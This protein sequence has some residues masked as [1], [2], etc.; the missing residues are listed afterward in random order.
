MPKKLK[1]SKKVVNP[2]WQNEARDL[3]SAI[4]SLKRDVEKYKRDQQ[5]EF[6][7]LLDEV[8]GISYFLEKEK[9]KKEIEEDNKEV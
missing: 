9:L 2:Y 5:L 6:R 4:D 7:L 1:K 3:W 8:R